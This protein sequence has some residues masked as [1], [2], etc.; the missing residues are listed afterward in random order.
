[1][2]EGGGGKVDPTKAC[3]DHICAF[4]CSSLKVKDEAFN[5][6]LAG[7]TRY[8]PESGMYSPALI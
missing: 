4:V 2:A 8:T 6:L 5:K 1:M 7:E 3:F